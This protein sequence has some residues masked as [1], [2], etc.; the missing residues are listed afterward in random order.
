MLRAVGAGR[1]SGCA[2]PAREVLPDL[3]FE[4]RLDLWRELDFALSLVREV[5]AFDAEAEAAG[6]FFFAVAGVSPEPLNA[7]SVPA[8]GIRQR[9]QSSETKNLRDI[10][11][12]QAREPASLRAEAG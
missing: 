12:P 2:R 6:V 4:L 1:C 3:V 11:E 8:G 7:A 9:R 10:R 5:A